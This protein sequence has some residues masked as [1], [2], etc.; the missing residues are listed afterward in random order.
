M[1]VY[2]ALA[3][4]HAVKHFLR[5]T[6]N[7]GH[8][9][10]VLTDSMTAA[11]SYDKGRAHSHRLRRVLEQFSALA[12]ATGLSVRTRWIPSEWNP[13]DRVSRGGFEPSEPQRDFNDSSPAGSFG[14]LVQ[15]P[16]EKKERGAK[17]DT[18]GQSS[19]W[20]VQ[21][22][23]DLAC[24]ARSNTKCRKETKARFGSWLR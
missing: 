3:T 17:T 16:K 12:L 7:H 20:G 1:P 9:L 24:G 18:S 23:S 6:D 10:L 5:N 21:C 15:S 2:E 8:R 22:A 4:L 13:A 11:L 14:E 19:R